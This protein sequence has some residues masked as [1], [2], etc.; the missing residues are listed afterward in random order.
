MGATLIWAA[1]ACVALF[2]QY[3]ACER[4]IFFAR[5]R[6][7]DAHALVCF[8][9]LLKANRGRCQNLGSLGLD[10]LGRI[11]RP[12]ADAK[13]AHQ[14]CGLELEQVQRYG[15]VLVRI[16]E[17]STG[18]GLLGTVAGMMR[19]A[20]GA[21]DPTA[22]VGL[23]MGTTVT[24]LVLA[25][26][27]TV[28]DSVIDGRRNSLAEQLGQVLAVFS[29]IEFEEVKTDARHPETAA[30]KNDGANVPHDRTLHRHTGELPGG[31]RSRIAGLSRV[32]LEA[33]DSPDGAAGGNGHAGTAT[34]GAGRIAPVRAAHVEGQAGPV[35]GVRPI[36]E[37]RNRHA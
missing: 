6:P 35:S 32:G 11:V 29:R 14:I 1:L 30:F 17:I 21:P 19:N 20:V 36:G 4:L 15:H 9:A 34:E 13:M 5:R 8:C 12:G 25:L 27:F 3:V 24:G 16:S 7:A 18:L 10:W 33:A 26:V 28:V 37:P 31:H 23:S 22:L 2:G